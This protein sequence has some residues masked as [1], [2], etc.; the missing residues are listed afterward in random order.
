M[1]MARIWLSVAAATNTAAYDGADVTLQGF[2]TPGEGD[3]VNLTRLVITHCVIDAQTARLPVWISPNTRIIAPHL[4]QSVQVT[5]VDAR[6]E[7]VTVAEG[8][9]VSNRAVLV[10]LAATADAA[11][12]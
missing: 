2:V 3:G 11:A 4:Q 6:I 12:S 7:S 10:T 1:S 9:Q 8:Q 5:G